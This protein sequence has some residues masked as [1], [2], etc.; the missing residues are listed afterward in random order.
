MTQGGKAQTSGVIDIHTH[1]V[2]ENF[3]AYAGKAGGANWPSMVPAEPCHRHVMVA[4]NVF[5]TVS[6]QCWD[7]NVRQADMDRTQVARQVLSPMP[8]LL[9]YWFDVEDGAA[10]CRYLNDVIA[11]MVAR[12]PTRFSGL[13][14]VPLQ[15]VDAAI[16]ELEYIMLELKLSGV[17]IATNINGRVIGDPQFEPFFA[18]AERLNAAVFVHPLRPTATERIVGPGVLQ[19]AL[20][21]PTDTGMAAA[22]MISGGTFAKYPKLRI[23]YS[24]GGGTF[25]SLLPRFQFV[26]ETLPEMKK[27]VTLEPKV[28]ARRMFY[29]S[30]V[31]DRQAAEHLIRVFGEDQV[32]S[33]SDYP[34]SIMEPEPSKF[35]D[36]LQVS[37]QVRDKLRFANARRWLGL[38]A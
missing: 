8:E 33:G 14:A 29:D 15:D 2:P 1:V 32:M 22:S 31:Y 30:L 12:D 10:I 5:R 16:R 26:W 34:F 25:A 6:H 38:A 7:C 11:E 24:H 13:G 3:P 20:A 17:E 18:A 9:S 35:L 27:A 23:A 4:N 28:A 36:A 37:D 21:F 19:A